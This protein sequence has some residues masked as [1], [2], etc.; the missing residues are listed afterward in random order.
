MA[1]SKGCGKVF[2]NQGSRV[3][4]EAK[5]GGSAQ[6]SRGPAPARAFAAFVPD[7]TWRCWPCRQGQQHQGRS[8]E[9][10]AL[11][12]FI[13]ARVRESSNVGRNAGNEKRERERERKKRGPAGPK[14]HD[15]KK[16]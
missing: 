4:H 8:R 3:K 10:L 15:A 14:K 9:A 11:G 2:V 12:W 1:C 7:S 13:A 5:C 6:A 16:R